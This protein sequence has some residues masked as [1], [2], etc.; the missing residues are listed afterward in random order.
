MSSSAAP[1]NPKYELVDLPEV[2]AA[3]TDRNVFDSAR[4]IVAKVVS[5]AWGLDADKIF[6][7]VDTGEYA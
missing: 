3:N 7:G 6:A 4:L 5:E 1:I 2:A